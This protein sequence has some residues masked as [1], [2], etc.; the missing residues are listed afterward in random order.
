MSAEE[1]HRLGLSELEKIRAEMRQV[2]VT[3]GYPEDESLPELYRRAAKDGGTLEGREVFD[4]YVRKIDEAKTETAPL[5]SRVPSADV[6]VQPDPIGGFYM[7]PS[8]DGSRPGIFYASTGGSTPSYVIPTLVYHETVPGHHT[9]LALV[10][11]LGMPLFKVCG[12]FQWLRGG[13]G[14]LCR[15][16]DG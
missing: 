9:Q 11:E 2:F 13:L 3:L 4:A 16:V 10:G 7:P 5:F 14:T 12:K 8:M 1:I 15:K 6:V